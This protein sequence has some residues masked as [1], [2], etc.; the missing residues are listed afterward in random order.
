MVRAATV[1][2]TSKAYVEATLLVLFGWI[3]ILKYYECACRSVLV[4]AMAARHTLAERSL[5]T[6]FSRMY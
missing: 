5:L 3:T 2:A 6:S 1:M 4:P